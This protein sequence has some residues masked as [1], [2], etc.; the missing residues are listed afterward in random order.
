M[1]R[2]IDLTGCLLTLS[3]Y[4]LLWTEQRD[5]AQ[6]YSDPAR[7]RKVRNVGRAAGKQA[8]RVAEQAPIT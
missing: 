6:Q 8:F 4:A 3:L 7:F 2:T 5:A 1:L